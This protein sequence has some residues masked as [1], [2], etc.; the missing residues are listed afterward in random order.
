MMTKRVREILG[1]YASENPGVLTNLARFL[2]HGRLAGT[3]HLVILP[4]DQGFEHGPARSF[5]VNPPAYNPQYHF[6]LARDAGCNGYAAPL[7][8]LEAG[9]AEYAGELPLI[10]KLNNHDVLLDERDPMPA[11]T[12]SVKDALRLGCAAVGFTIYPGSTARQQMYQQLQEIAAEAKEHG[13]AVV[14]WSYPRGSGLSKEGETAL[15]VVAYA[16]QIA[17]Q[18]GANIVK[19]KLPSAHL[20]QPEARKAYE[21]AGVALEPLSA[22][23]AHV[24]QSCFD[25]RRIVIFSGGPKEEDK[26]LLEEVAAI[27]AGGGYGSIIGRNSF[28]RPKPDAIALLSQIMKIYAS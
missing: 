6:E 2:N 20:E 25:G 8:F 12:G 19:V 7:G 13:L 27:R 22:R 17:A 14:V 21:A 3:G 11:V 4:V 24:V 10:L 1:Y 18:L 26:A 5:A 15:D 16:A 28:Q 23:V 9:A